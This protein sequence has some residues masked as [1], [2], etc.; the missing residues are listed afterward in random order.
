MNLLTCDWRISFAI[1]MLLAIFGSVIVWGFL[2]P[3]AG[4][5]WSG[6]CFAFGAMWAQGRKEVNEP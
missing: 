6:A 5:I 1:L 2:G 4:G 3:F